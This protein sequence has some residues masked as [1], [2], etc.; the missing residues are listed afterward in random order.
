M[1]LF[2]Y[3]YGCHFGYILKKKLLLLFKF[4]ATGPSL[5]DLAF[6]VDILYLCLKLKAT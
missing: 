3:Q 5:V 6:L 2:N 1:E 4:I